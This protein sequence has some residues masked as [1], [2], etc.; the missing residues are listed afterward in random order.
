[1]FIL[2]LIYGITPTCIL[3][4]GDFCAAIKSLPRVKIL[5]RGGRKSFSI[6]IGGRLLW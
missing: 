5:R 1:M 4:G 3:G 6:L 2:Q